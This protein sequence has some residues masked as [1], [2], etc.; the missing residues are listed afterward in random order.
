MPMNPTPCS[1]L[2][3]VYLL[4]EPASLLVVA[5]THPLLSLVCQQLPHPLLVL[6]PFLT[7][8]IKLQSLHR[9]HQQHQPS[10][11]GTILLL[12][13]SIYKTSPCTTVPDET[14]MYIRGWMQMVYC[15]MIYYPETKQMNFK[16]VILS[17]MSWDII[18]VYIQN[19]NYSQ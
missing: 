9:R 16:W 8:Q 7:P 10:S 1:L 5:N 4:K 19:G 17:K 3:R 15:Q 11:S 2:P 13:Y 6:P 18:T 14:M 12:L